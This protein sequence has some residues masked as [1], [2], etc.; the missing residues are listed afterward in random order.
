MAI[1][2]EDF[3]VLS[4]LVVQLSTSGLSSWPV[5]DG[6]SSGAAVQGPQSMFTLG[7]RSCLRAYCANTCGASPAVEPIRD[8]PE[9]RPRL[10]GLARS[11]AVKT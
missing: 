5:E 9:P 4:P 7:D 1:D 10:R 2:G 8:L 6:P 11:G 3:G